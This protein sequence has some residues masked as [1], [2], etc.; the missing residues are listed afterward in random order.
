[1]RGDQRYERD[2]YS[3]SRF[4]DDGFDDTLPYDGYLEPRRR[5][6]GKKILF[7]VLSVF[8]VVLIVGFL[9]LNALISRIEYEKPKEGVYT[10]GMNTSASKEARDIPLS[11]SSYVTNILFLGSDSGNGGRSDTNLILSIDRKNKKIKLTSFLRDLYVEIPEYR[12]T[13]LNAAFNNGGADRVI[14]TIEA[15]FRI[16][17][18]AYFRLDFLSMSELVN[19]V[20]GIN[21]ELTQAEANYIMNKTKIPTSAGETHLSG[22]QALWYCR[23]RKL[24]SDFGRTSRQRN[25]INFMLKDFKSRS[26]PA[27]YSFLH[28]M[29]PHLITR[30]DTKGKM[31]WYLFSGMMALN[32]E[33]EELTIPIDGGYS[34]KTISG[35]AVL[36][37]N[38]PK[39]CEALREFIYG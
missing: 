3:T 29:M 9:L 1:M 31:Y 36:V 25:F 2:L 16:K 10:P 7:S 33:T 27:Q 22:W 39:N 6:T 5:N 11:S 38:I 21:C 13:R 4:P 15:N 18:D 37:P 19:D 14:Q 28:D 30:D 26:L 34:S 24:D 8:F 23:I 12:S 35:A 17:I 32:Y 20:G